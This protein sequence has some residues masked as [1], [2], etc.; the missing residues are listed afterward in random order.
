MTIAWSGV[1]GPILFS[2]AMVRAI[3]ENR[4]TNT[5]RLRN[6]DGVNANPGAWY[7]CALNG[8]GNAVFTQDEKTYTE[9]KNPYGDKGDR[10]WVRESFRVWT[11]HIVDSEDDIFGGKLTSDDSDRPIEYL[12]D[13]GRDDLPWRPSIH[14]PRWASRLTLEI[15]KVRVERVQNISEADAIAEGVSLSFS[16]MYWQGGTSWTDERNPAFDPKRAITGPR[17][18]FGMLWDSINSKRDD[19][20]FAWNKNPW[21]WVIEFKRVEAHVS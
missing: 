18:A 17:A 5:R 6:L 20:K 14:M 10:L 13:S 19:G 2:G 4:K 15:V 9:V 12:A 21:V 8:R 1:D 7:F 3:L 11:R 16:D